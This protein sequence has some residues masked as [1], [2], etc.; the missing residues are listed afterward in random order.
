M[1]RLR[2]SADDLLHGARRHERDEPGPDRQGGRGVHHHAASRRSGPAAPP[3]RPGRPA[4]RGRA[5]ERTSRPV[6]RTGPRRGRQRA[7]PS[8]LPEPATVRR[9][10]RRVHAARPDEDQ[11]GRRRSHRTP[12]DP[13]RRRHHGGL[14]PLRRHRGTRCRRRRG[15]PEDPCR[16]QQR[17][18][19]PAPPGRGA[20]EWHLGPTGQRAVHRC[21]VLGLRHRT[22]GGRRHRTERGRLPGARPAR[23]RGTQGTPV[24]APGS[25][26]GQMGRR[27][28]R[29][30]RYPL[31]GQGPGTEPSVPD[32]SGTHPRRL[33]GPA[34]LSV[35]TVLE[36][37]QPD[38]SAVDGVRRCSLHHRPV[39]LLPLLLGHPRSLLPEHDF[40]LIGLQS[41]AVLAV[42]AGF[43][44]GWAGSVAG[45][46]ARPTQPTGT[47]A[48]WRER[49]LV[50]AREE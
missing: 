22:G 14:L 23:A 11:L 12:G 1:H 32:P 18:D 15:R 48:R 40:H 24:R 33:H 31:G 13:L 4:G 27:S 9:P 43:L 30:A 17:P 20:G 45:R 41:T 26:V 7:R 34:R 2:R 6:L 44:L 49:V 37:V 42:P 21:R 5:G 28:R 8:R 16:R 47:D 35:R 10:G 39:R 29:R 38:R 25:P 3:L 46:R 19:G 36:P 50:G